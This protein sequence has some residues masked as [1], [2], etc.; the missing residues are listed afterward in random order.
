MGNKQSNKNETPEVDKEDVR[1]GPVKKRGCTDILCLLL[2]L[3]FI[4]GWIFVAYLAFS[5]GDI[6]KVLHPTDSKGKVC[7]RGELKDKPYLMFF[8]LTKCLNLAVVSLG[9]PTVQTC[10]KECPNFTKRFKEEGQKQ[11]MK[12]FCVSDLSVEKM[13]RKPVQ[14]LIDE[15]LCPPF[16]LESEEKLGRCIPKPQ[17]ENIN[18]NVISKDIL[19]R[20]KASMFNFN[21]ANSFFGKK[22]YF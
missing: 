18:T 1:D 12:Q 3:A 20:G 2:F 9:C 8:D 6:D 13:N 7:G 17:A 22:S 4:G 14:T 21:R 16:I 10:V 5:Q 15:K 19:D 11:E